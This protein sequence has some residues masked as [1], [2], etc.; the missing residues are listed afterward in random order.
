MEHQH[1]ISGNIGLG[2]AFKLGI[3]IN[4][5]F[6]ILEVGY[7]LLSNSM[8]LI[9]D[10][11]HNFG[12]VLTL[13]FSWIAITLSKRSAT[14]KFTYGYQKTTILAALLNTILLLV[15]VGII[16]WEAIGRIGK[17]VEINSLNVIVVATIGIFINGITAW[18]FLKDRKH[19][20][21]IRSAFIHFFADALVS[22][23]VVLSGI[24]I[25]FTGLYWIDIIVSL[26]IA[27]VIIYSSYHL[28]I[29]SV[30][31]S[32]DA[33]PEN[34]NINKVR[35]YLLNL[36]EV[37]DIHDLHIWAL[38]TSETALTVHIITEKQI[39]EN[40]I[41]TIQ[42]HLKLNFSINHST[43]QIEYYL[44]NDNEYNCN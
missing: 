3:L 25:L 21:N 8:A 43:V 34:I 19:D 6:I 26:L 42:E 14:L 28:L 18:L 11:G 10:A 31:L 4:I 2:K 29:D 20:L 17:V 32:L 41:S 9:A 1:S 24:I 16:I 36:P 39:P 12:D 13:V 44:K 40:F 15:A 33:V 22:L 35:E 27:L 38:S 30:N 7:G 23:G 37:K 5:A